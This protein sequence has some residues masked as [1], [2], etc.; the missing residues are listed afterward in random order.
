M[1]FIKK[2]ARRFEEGYC[3]LSC[4]QD[5]GSLCGMNCGTFRLWNKLWM[6]KLPYIIVNYK[7]Y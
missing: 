3:F 2:P 5:C 4:N 6:Y 1:K 7:F